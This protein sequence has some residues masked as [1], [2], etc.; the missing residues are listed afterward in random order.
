MFPGPRSRCDRAHHAIAASVMATSTISEMN[1]VTPA[2]GATGRNEMMASC[3]SIS[4]SSCERPVAS[5]TGTVALPVVGRQVE[6]PGDPVLGPCRRHSLRIARRPGRRPV[7]PAARCAH[8]GDAM[9]YLRP[10]GGRGD[11]R[12]DHPSPAAGR[13]VGDRTVVDPSLHPVSRACGRC[14]PRSSSRRTP[15]E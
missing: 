13:V 9:R 4:R 2:G 12:I 10:V 1:S 3:S 5:N 6:R 15:P 11:E 14:C 7:S 8:Y